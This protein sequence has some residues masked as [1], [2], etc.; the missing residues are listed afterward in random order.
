MATRIEPTVGRVVWYW[1]EGAHAR[2]EQPRSASVAHVIARDG[3]PRGPQYLNIGYLGT[4]GRHW[5]AQRVLLWQGEELD[6]PR[7]LGPH[8]EW[9]PYQKGQAART[10][11]LEEQAR[12]T[13]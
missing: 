9:M 2:N 12:R 1:P 8:C 5:D 10:E 7:P 13:T 4:D 11:A 6:G 3:D